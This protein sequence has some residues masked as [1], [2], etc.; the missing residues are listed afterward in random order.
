MHLRSARIADIPAIQRITFQ[1]ALLGSSASV[2]W[3]DSSL[4]FDLAYR[5]YLL[6]P[7][8]NAMVAEEQ[9]RILGYILFA[10]QSDKIKQLFFYR[11]LPFRVLPRLLKGCYHLGPKSLK[12]MLRFSLDQLFCPLGGLALEK[13]APAILHINVDPNA[14]GKGVG[15]ALL[16]QAFQVLKERGVP[17]VHLHTTSFNQKACAL[18]QKFGFKEYARKRTYL[19]QN[20]INEKVFKLAYVKKL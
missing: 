11:I 6:P 14:Q 13:E 17:G 19:W 10:P 8:E 3:E 4:Y 5:V 1:T 7:L 9:G 12:F 2:F 20:W 16:K 18:Y 15:S